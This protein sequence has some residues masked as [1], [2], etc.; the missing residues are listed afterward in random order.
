VALTSLLLGS[1]LSQG[2]ASAAV[3][4][5][6]AQSTLKAATLAVAGQ[7]APVSANVLALAEGARQALFVAPLKMAGA[8]AA[9]VTVAAA[10]SVGA[11]AFVSRPES[12]QPNPPV[13]LVQT[14]AQQ[15]PV[16]D[17]TASVPE[18]T[19]G[20]NFVAGQSG[21]ATFNGEVIVYPALVAA[22]GDSGVS[23][24]EDARTGQ[25]LAPR[26]QPYQRHQDQATESPSGPEAELGPMPT[27]VRPKSAGPVWWDWMWVPW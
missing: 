27:L 23:S 6:L 19:G 7:S 8:M 25:Q 15:N 14:E 5:A 4:A 18:T 26:A 10:L 24:R 21:P 13:A 22:P 12:A 20:Q 3:P 17:G 1:L 16:D 2:T 11:I 9:S